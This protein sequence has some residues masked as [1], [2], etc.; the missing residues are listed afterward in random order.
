M[1]PVTAFALCKTAYSTIKGAIDVYKDLKK[2]GGDVANITSEIGG[3]LSSFFKGTVAIEE[4]HEEQ[5]I[6][7]E[8]ALKSGKK[9]E[10]LSQAI[11]TVILVRQTQQYYK[12]LEH[13]VR[14]ELGMP[15]L[16]SEIVAEY[17]K[18]VAERDVRLAKEKT[19]TAR[20]EWQRQRVIQEVQDQV[21]VVVA[22][23]IVV[24]EMWGLM[25]TIHATRHG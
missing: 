3:A 13:M 10:L 11:D 15:D 2:T 12:D 19:E 24:L 1:D 14:W 18:L 5:K 25:W 6:K 23:L 8:E 7:R 17:N 16:W 4:H 21:I 20:K 9:N 22:V